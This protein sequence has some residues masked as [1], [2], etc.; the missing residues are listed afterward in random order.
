MTIVIAWLTGLLLDIL[1]NT[2]MGTSALVLVIVTYLIIRFKNK[3]KPHF[4][5]YS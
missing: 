3:R 5:N 1:F 2:P 4:E